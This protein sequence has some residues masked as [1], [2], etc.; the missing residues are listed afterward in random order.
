MSAFRSLLTVT[1]KE[2]RDL[3][4][5]R[6]T[7]MIALLMMPL[8]VPALILGVGMMAEKRARTLLSRRRVGRPRGCAA[9]FTRP[10]ALARGCDTPHSLLPALWRRRGSER[11]GLR[12]V[13]PP[14]LLII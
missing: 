13:A 8:L 10:R 7:V 2:L 4:R 3:F 11:R 14:V 5:D 9:L 1:R 12:N 6:R